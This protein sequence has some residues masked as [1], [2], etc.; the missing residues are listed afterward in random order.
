MYPDWM[1]HEPGV[2]RAANGYARRFP[3]LVTAEE[4]YVAGLWGLYLAGS[5]YERAKDPGGDFGGWSGIYVRRAM[6]DWIRSCI[7]PFQQPRRRYSGRKDR[8][9][10]RREGAEMMERVAIEG[11][12]AAV[13]A[14]DFCAALVPRLPLPQQAAI[15]MRLAGLSNA[16]IGERMGWN[17]SRTEHQLFE[18]RR[19]L[20][21][22]VA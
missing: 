10:N 20:R 2:R 12:F 22:M 17:V 14:G 16:E 15:R 11:A 18:A 19:R 4:L 1:K 5:L 9:R 13:D 6:M 8:A 3:G 21:A 7:D